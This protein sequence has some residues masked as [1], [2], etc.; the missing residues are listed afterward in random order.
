[1]EE[2]KRPF[3]MLPLDRPTKF[4]LSLN[5]IIELQELTGLD[6]E[7]P[8]QFA[9]AALGEIKILRTIIFCGIKADR[10]ELAE[11]TVGELIDMGNIEEVT[12][13]VFGHMGI[14]PVEED[15]AKKVPRATTP[16]RKAQKPKSGPGPAPSKRPA[17]SG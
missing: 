15:K 14:K 16:G 5:A 3:V 9:A 17:V 10:P 4:R 1:M 11:E 8:E 13:K 12:R 2:I 7:Q 6:L